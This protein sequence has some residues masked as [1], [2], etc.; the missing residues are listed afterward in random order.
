[1]LDLPVFRLALASSD[2]TNLLGSGG[3]CRVYPFGEAPKNVA[4]PYAVY[5][6]I[7]GQPQNYLAGSPDADSAQVQIDVYGSSP[8]AVRAAVKALAQ[9]VESG[10]YI[11][12]WGARSRDPKTRNYRIGFDAEFLIKR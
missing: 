7:G 8:S 4:H 5:Q 9:A 2:V 3:D 1:M 6:L 11:T 12:R 10:G